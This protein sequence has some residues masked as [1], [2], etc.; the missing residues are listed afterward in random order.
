MG[1]FH[2]ITDEARRMAA[3]RGAQKAD[4]STLQQGQRPNALSTYADNAHYGRFGNDTAGIQETRP[5]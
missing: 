5:K 3:A 2:V 1:L 4:Q